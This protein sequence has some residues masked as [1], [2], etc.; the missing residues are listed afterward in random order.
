M[1]TYD[2]AIYN[3]EKWQYLSYVHFVIHKLLSVLKEYVKK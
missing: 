3:S 1:K 2:A